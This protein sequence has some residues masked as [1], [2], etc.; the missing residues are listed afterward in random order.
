MALL[1]KTPPANA[2]DIRDVGLIPGSGRSPA[3]GRSNS[4]QYSRLENPHGQRSLSGYS[5]RDH[6]ESDTTKATEHAG[7]QKCRKATHFQTRNVSPGLP[8]GKF[9]TRTNKY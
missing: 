9:F 1:V 8:R 5:L 7:V 3:G 4:L 2:G 6:T